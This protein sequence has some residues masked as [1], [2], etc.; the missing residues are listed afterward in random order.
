MADSIYQTGWDDGF[1]NRGFRP[2]Y[3]DDDNYRTG[4]CN[5]AYFRAITPNKACTGLAPA[6]APES[7]VVSGASQ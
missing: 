3:S 4:F 1:E 7:I 5:G 2:E 6:V